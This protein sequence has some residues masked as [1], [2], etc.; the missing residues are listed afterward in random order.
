ME[1]GELGRP[2]SRFEAH[3]MTDGGLRVLIRFDL[4]FCVHLN[5]GIWNVRIDESVYRVQTWK[6]WRDSPESSTEDTVAEQR[7]YFSQ[8]T[9]T[10][11]EIGGDPS[12]ATK[13]SGVDVEMRADRH[14]RYRFSRC[15]VEL[16]HPTEP[17][18]EDIDEVLDEALRIV[19]RLVDVFRYST[20]RAYLPPLQRDDIDFAEIIIPDSGRGFFH[21][22][23]HGV[24][25]ALINEPAWVH[26]K[27]R[28]LLAKGAGVPLHAELLLTAR[29]MLAEGSYRQAVVEAVTS[30]DVLIDELLDEALRR[31]M[32]DADRYDESSNMVLS[33]RMKAPVREAVG[34]S[35]VEDDDIWRD[36]I[37]ANKVRRE[38]VHGGR[39]VTKEEAFAVVR[40]VAQIRTFFLGPDP[41]EGLEPDADETGNRG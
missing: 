7:R 35:P 18:G 31:E 28:E 20:N 22:N 9:V 38:A 21:S 26:E 6:R 2:S 5:D 32:I 1:L 24:G 23:L 36:W 41:A 12:S 33:D 17:S 27:V 29:R 13:M 30:L 34:K 19:N 39:T 4:P 37:A 25:A 14:G 3:V 8:S 16:R 10:T 15:A 40:A 11:G